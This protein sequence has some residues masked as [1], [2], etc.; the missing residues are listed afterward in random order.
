MTPR[1]RGATVRN[2]AHEIGTETPDRELVAEHP[3][4]RG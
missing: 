3:V 4:A 2:D 1:H